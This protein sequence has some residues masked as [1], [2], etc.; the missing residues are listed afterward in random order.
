MRSAGRSEARP[1]QAR[2]RA[3]RVVDRDREQVEIFGMAGA[4]G[5]GGVEQ[6]AVS[7]VGA[8]VRGH[9]RARPSGRRRAPR[10]IPSTSPVI[11]TN[12]A[13]TSCCTRAA[14]ASAVVPSRQAS[15]A[16][17]AR[18]T[19]AATAQPPA[20]TRV[21]LTRRSSRQRRSNRR[22][23]HLIG[24]IHDEA[25]SHSQRLGDRIPGT[26][27]SGSGEPRDGA[28]RRSGARERAGESEGRSPS[29][30]H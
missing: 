2:G 10:A 22:L 9:R 3:R 19:S 8:G 11:S 20:K 29:V 5:R 13:R 15:N 6:G 23:D 7:F 26:R 21:T 14:A 27:A 28:R 12:E 25:I 18:T 1:A 16:A 30:Y 24:R 4:R 17:P